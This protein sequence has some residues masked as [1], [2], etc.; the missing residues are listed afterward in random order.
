[1]RKCVL[2]LRAPKSSWLS[3]AGGTRLG[4]GDPGGEG[5]GEAERPG[6]PLSGHSPQGVAPRLQ[7]RR[8]R[9]RTR[10]ALP[11]GLGLVALS[12]VL[13]PASWNPGSGLFRQACGAPQ[14]RLPA[15]GTAG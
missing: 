13:P 11:W 3:A 10:A 1:M 7:A 5:R 4:R 2:N 15:R 8:A 9:A 12:A 14:K 6:A